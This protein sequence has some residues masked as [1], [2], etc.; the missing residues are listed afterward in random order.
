MEK[1]L[2]ILESGITQK[3]Q[4]ETLSGYEVISCTAEEAPTVLEQLQRFS[5]PLPGPATLEEVLEDL[6]PY[7]KP[8]VLSALHASL[9]VTFRDPDSLLTKEAYP[10]ACRAYG[11]SPDAVDQAIRRLLRKAWKHRHQQPGLWKG[12]FPNHTRCPS[13]WEFIIT[14]VR[15]LQKSTP[16][17]SG[18]GQDRQK[19][20]Y[21]RIT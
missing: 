11:G 6:R 17:V 19:D 13:N 16:P 14:V 8:R 12:L 5:D 10:E 2:L 3:L 7:G 4:L 15:Y 9:L 1:I 21:E 18:R 20:A